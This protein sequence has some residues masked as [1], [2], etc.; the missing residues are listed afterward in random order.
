MGFRQY[1]CPNCPTKQTYS[2]LLDRFYCEP[3]DQWIEEPCRCEPRI[4]EYAARQTAVMGMRPSVAHGA[5][6]QKAMAEAQ[7][8]LFSLEAFLQ[9][10]QGD[11]EL[12][13][14]DAA[15]PPGD[16]P[17]TKRGP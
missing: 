3:C 13:G 12:H 4:C 10:C 8:K 15:A 6:A 7:A 1:T 9:A 14:E 2:E 11:A 17:D 16:P 5:Q